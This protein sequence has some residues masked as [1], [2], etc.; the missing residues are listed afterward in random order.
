MQF[1]VPNN[2]TFEQAI[3]LAQEMLSLSLPADDDVLEPAIAALLQSANGARG[4][5]VT[6]LTGDSPLADMPTPGI[7]TALRSAPA[8]V[9]SLMV[10]N[11]AM[12]T[13][14]QLHHQRHDD[15]VNAAGS[16]RVQARSQQLIHALAMPLMQTELQQLLD[17]VSTGSGEYQDFLVRWGYD[18]AQLQAI[19]AV[20]QEII[21]A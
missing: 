9:A 11:L 21:P 5:F 7:L 20:I 1:T 6:F 2:V 10:K 17:S 14:M 3:G 8:I 12:S 13:A 4:F 16:A 19:Q 15:P 18:Q